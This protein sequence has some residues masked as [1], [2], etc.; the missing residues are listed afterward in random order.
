MAAKPATE[1]AASTVC[2]VAAAQPRLLT[3]EALPTWLQDNAYILRGY[4]RYNTFHLLIISTLDHEDLP[5]A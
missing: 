1:V 4:R 3:Y 2:T 5:R